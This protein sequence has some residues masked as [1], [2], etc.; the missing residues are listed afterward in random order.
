VAAALLVAGVT[1]WA[2]E[3]SGV[4]IVLMQAA[5][6]QTRSTPVWFAERDGSLW[7]EAGSP[8]NPWYRDV[9]HEPRLDLVVAGHRRTWIAEPVDEPQ[10]RQSLRRALRAKY[11]L[12]DGWVGL[13][14]DASR[15]VPVRLVPAR[16]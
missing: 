8:E 6:G 10:R 4:A 11:G 2:L 1:W 5:P 7:L 14:V 15:S 3:A 12:R 16:D 13:F 9:L